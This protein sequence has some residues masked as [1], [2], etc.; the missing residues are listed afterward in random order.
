MAAIIKDCSRTRAPNFTTIEKRL[1]LD[2]GEQ[3]VATIEY[4]KTNA[5]VIHVR[6]YVVKTKQ[7]LFTFT[8]LESQVL[9]TQ[10][11]VSVHHGRVPVILHCANVAV[12]N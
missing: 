2:I 12:A 5:N 7:I 6:I 9:W 8:A 3:F 1:L 11:T 10:V 4:K